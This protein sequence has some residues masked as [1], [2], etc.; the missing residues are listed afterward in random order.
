MKDEHKIIIVAF[1]F[2]ILLGMFLSSSF[3]GPFK[4]RKYGIQ[5][6]IIETVK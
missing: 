1:I 6:K 3:K 4:I 2:G 5:E